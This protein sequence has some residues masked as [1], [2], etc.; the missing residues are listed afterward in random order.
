MLLAAI[1]NFFS[2]FNANQ[3]FW[4][5]YSGGL[6]SH[7]LLALCAE[8]HRMTPIQLNVIHINHGLH[9]HATSWALHCAKECETYGFKYIERVIQLKFNSGDSLEAVARHERYTTFASYMNE[10]DVLLTAHQQDDQA[11][12]VLLQLLRGAGL[13]GLAAMPA[14]NSFRSGF[15]AR[16]LLNFPRAVLQAYAKQHQLSWIEDPSNDDTRLTR[17]YIRKEIL[18]RLKNRWPSATNLLARSASHCSEAQVLLEEIIVIEWLKVIGSR[19]NTLSVKKL[20]YLD[21]AKQRLVLRAWFNRL[22]HPMPDMKKMTSICESVLPAKNDRMPC[23]RWQQTE[24][25]R[26]RDDLYLIPRLLPHDSCQVV[27]WGLTQPLL[28]PGLGELC[29]SLAEGY[30]LRADIK[31]VSLRFRC[32]GEVYCLGKRGRH[33]LK[34]LFQEWKV[35]PWERNRIPLIFVVEQLVMVLGYYL[36]EEFA[37]TGHKMG[38]RIFFKNHS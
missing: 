35:P 25:R 37:A 26:Y 16:P 30:G 12:T 3:I 19:V 36:A 8:Y 5:G 10:G 31:H 34:N 1:S 33:Y 27:D 7:V 14:I 11:E 22:G 28:L 38:Y 13:K 24:L 17:N 9:H 2:K 21:K 6:D 29:A 32:G 18:P 20:L 15:H 23:I 4:L